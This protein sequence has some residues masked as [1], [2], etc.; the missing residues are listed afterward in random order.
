MNMNMNILQLKKFGVFDIILLALFV[1]YVVFPVPTPQWLVPF[2]DSPFG[3]V[4]I[5]AVAVSLFVYRSPVL[6]VLFIF[7]AYELL[8]RNHYV[9]PASPIVAETKYSANRVPQKIPTQ[10]EKNTELQSMN[11]PQLRTLEEEVISK[12]SPVGV[13]QL[14]VG[15]ETSFHP[16]N[17]KTTLGM[18][19]A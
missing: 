19:L 3:M 6:G 1:I 4:L 18:T 17:D 8:R 7:V 5:F 9:A 11:P 12:E 14:P 16:A 2:I 10:S 13:S 15:L